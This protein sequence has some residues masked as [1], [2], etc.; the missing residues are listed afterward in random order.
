MHGLRAPQNKNSGDGVDNISEHRPLLI[1]LQVMLHVFR[2]RASSSHFNAD[3][4]PVTPSRTYHRVS[5]GLSHEL[6]S[7]YKLFTTP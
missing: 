6:V 1:K 7:T 3:A 5:G 4:L 2:Y